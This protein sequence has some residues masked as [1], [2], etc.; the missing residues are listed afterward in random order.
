MR[1]WLKKK[2]GP[3]SPGDVM[4]RAIILKHLI[5]KAMATP[6]LDD[7][8]RCI[9]N[10]SEQEKAD[11][12][13]EMKRRAE[14]ETQHL[15]K[16]GLWNDM[17]SSEQALIEAGPTEMSAQARIDASWLVESAICLL[18]ALGYVSELSRYDQQV[19]PQLTNLLPLES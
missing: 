19:D 3:P 10:W 14:Q 18:W 12:N 9:D 2:T 15:R 11:L 1:A 16:T 17:D 4:K 8:A 13:R 6:P 7:L 5:V